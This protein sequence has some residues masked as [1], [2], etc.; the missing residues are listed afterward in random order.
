MKNLQSANGAYFSH[1]TP[2]VRSQGT[3][4]R[5][6]WLLTLR[7]LLLALFLLSIYTQ[8]SLYVGFVIP[9]TFTLLILM[10]LLALMYY[11]RIYKYELFFVG[12]VF[13]I[14]LLTAFLS[15]G[16]EYLDQKL[17]GLIQTIASII[18]GILLLKLVSNLPNQWLART[19]L[20]LWVVL[21]VGAALEVVG[22]LTGVSDAFREAA[23]GQGEG[24]YGIYDSSSRDTELIGHERPKLFTS[25]PSFLA[26][27]F[28]AFINSWLIV[29]YSQRNLFVACMATLL[30]LGLSGS[31]ILFLSLSVS[32]IVMLFSENRVDYSVLALASICLVVL[33]AAY[34]RSDIAS[35]FMVRASDAYQNAGSAT[36]LGSENRR[37]FFPFITVVDVIKNSPL[38]GIGIS[39]KELVADYSSLPLDPEAAMGDNALAMFFMYCG[40]VGSPLFI[41]AVYDYW[42]RMRIDQIMLLVVPILALSQT[43]GGFETPRFWGYTFLFV[44][45]MWKR[46]TS[47]HSTPATSSGNQSQPRHAHSSAL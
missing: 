25:E 10:P 5:R 28:F 44:A 2:S 37:L 43:M 19:L 30:M 36:H 4:R 39:G 13:L 35:D 29:A 1:G 15:P 3:K 40:L 45:V 18:G 34:I 41:K 38:F 9:S 46:S 22:V 8:V 17:L 31:P 47:R 12:Q 32:I 21:L 33:A 42:R 6:S 23:Y 26:I 24:T 20:A 11:R 7:V 27:G 16:L 14:L